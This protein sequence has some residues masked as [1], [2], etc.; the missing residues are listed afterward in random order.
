MYE[1]RGGGAQPPALWFQPAPSEPVRLGGGRLLRSPSPLL[2]T[3]HGP[4]TEGALPVRPLIAHAQAQSVGHLNPEWTLAHWEVHRSRQPSS[5]RPDTSCPTRCTGP[6]GCSGMEGWG[7][8]GRLPVTVPTRATW[9]R[10]VGHVWRA[11]VRAGAM[12]AC[13][14][15]ASGTRMS[16]RQPGRSRIQRCQLAWQQT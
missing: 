12:R 13:S 15:R 10:C 4:S 2:R 1:E 7:S 14:R 5:L 16:K 6:G 11:S 9:R 3:S 8:S